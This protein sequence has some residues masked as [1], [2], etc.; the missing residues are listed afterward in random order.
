MSGNKVERGERQGARTIMKRKKTALGESAGE[1]DMLER[2]IDKDMSSKRCGVK[3][4]VCNEDT[5]ISGNR[6]REDEV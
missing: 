6:V 1:S 4:R 2:S 3:S 5:R